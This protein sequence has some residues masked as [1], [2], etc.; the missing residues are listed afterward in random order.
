[1]KLED[2]TSLTERCFRGEPASCSYA[3]PFHMDIRSF[4]DKAAKG[5]WGAA[6]KIFRNATVFPGIVAVLCEQPCRER[7]QRSVVGDEAIALRDI[8]AACLR[9]AKDRRPESYVIPP[10]EKRVAVVG[11][12]LAGLS[13]ALDLAQKKFLVTVFD[14][15]EGWGGCLRPHP[16]FAEFDAEIAL[17]FSAVKAEF[18]FGTEVKSLDELD[19]FDAVY[20]ATGAGG[21]SFGLCEGWDPDLFTT[22]VPRVFLG[23]ALCGA[24]LMEGIAQGAEVS[25]IIEVFLQTGRAAHTPS[26]FDKSGRGH[27]LT[28][29]GAVSVPRVEPSSPEGYTDEEAKAE[30]ARCL[31]CDC[32]YCFAGCEMLR[33]F[34]KDP[35]KIGVEV[36]T[37]MNVNPPFSTRALT[38]E[39]YSC[40]ICGYCESVCPESV[41]IG[42]AMQLSRTARMS[43]GVDPAALHDYWLREMD[44]STSEGAFA[45]APKGRDACEYAFYPGCQLGA[46]NP[47]HVLRAY[48][49]LK[50]KYD[51]GIILG[52][53]GAPAYWAGDEERL[54]SNIEEIRRQWH[55]MGE[56][57]LIFA[58]ATCESLFCRSLPEIPRVSLYQLLAEAEDI[59]PTKIF[60]EAAIFDPCAARGD[61]E[62]EAGVRALAGKAGVSLEELPERNRCCGYGGHIQLANP[63]LYEEITAHRAEASDRPYIVYCANCRE[64][65]ASRDKECVHVLDMAFGLPLSGRAPSLQEKRDNSLRVKKELMKE[66][67]DVDFKP[68]SHPWDDLTLIIDADLQKDLDEQLISAADLKEA[69]WVAESEGD[70][71]VDESGGTTIASMVKRV[72]TYWVEYRK[73]GPKT[74]EIVDAYYHRMRFGREE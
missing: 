72:I 23:G 28:H 35:R 43:A 19:G 22:T 46:S 27:Y 36:Y 67:K 39:A 60:S 44:F 3:C 55:D 10:K 53:C 51:A 6:Y 31:Q 18:R 48:G 16:R 63:E 21:E 5:R 74:Y 26:E 50:E 58:C 54:Q 42:R 73:T 1:M 61:P 38:R 59:V 25:K 57:T 24:T 20:V 37:D 12:G 13:L 14:K 9:Y 15:E 45:S 70:R 69:I 41:D 8:E 2:A 17:Q 56:P 4:L 47:E 33:R 68:E 11:A 34:R 32:D 62:M 65:F 52:C 64:V 7:C 66:I 49:F 40:N 30:A 29:D 71:F